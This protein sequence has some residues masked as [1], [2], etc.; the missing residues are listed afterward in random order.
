MNDNNTKPQINEVT[1]LPF[2]DFNHRQKH[3]LTAQRIKERT[4]EVK[5]AGNFV[6]NGYKWQPIEYEGFAIISMVNEHEDNAPLTERLIQIQEELHDNLTP[7]YGFYQ[8]PPESFHQ[9]IAN[10][11]SADRFKRNV[12]NKGLESKYPDMVNQAFN[13]FELE[14]FDYPIGMKMLGLSVFGTAI[15]ALGV[16]ENEEE[17][18]RIIN[19]RAGFYSN[20]ALKELDVRMT[21][22]F[23]GHITLAYVEHGLN[24]NQKD[25]LA[26]VLNE[27]NETM[28][29]ERNYFNISNT[30]LRRY[31]H[32]AEFKKQP[33]Y[34]S[35]AI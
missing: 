17:Y 35:K 24:K 13:S 10:T 12:L 19:F 7:S 20:P 2:A 4:L 8:L 22:P 23:I 16:F 31:H 18:N 29:E 34:P 15:G 6:Y 33:N 32:L 14:A 9:T 11:L 1:D 5:P 21:R 30:G 28:A 26:T 3:E 27:I 25:Q